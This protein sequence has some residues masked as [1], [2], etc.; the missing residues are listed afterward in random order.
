MGGIAVIGGAVGGW[1]M[2]KRRKM[3]KD[4]GAR[5]VRDGAEAGSP[6]TV[7][8][9]GMKQAYVPVSEAGAGSVVRQ[10]YTPISEAEGRPV[11]EMDSRG[12][13]ELG[14]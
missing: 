12:V 2:V 9:L 7:E 3:R 11:M 13:H 8:S 14:G 10:A 6:G 5:G 4:K 1:L